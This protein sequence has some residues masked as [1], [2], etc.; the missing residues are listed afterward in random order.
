MGL[1]KEIVGVSDYDNYPK[2]A[3][4]KEKIGGQEFNTE[5]IIALKPNLVLAHAS[6]ANS[7]E[8]CASAA[9]GCRYYCSGRQQ[10]AKL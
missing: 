3:L 8:G 7:C 4:K 2:D 10:C 9:S 5:K 6:S 1:D